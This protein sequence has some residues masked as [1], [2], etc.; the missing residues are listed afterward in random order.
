MEEVLNIDERGRIVIPARV[1]KA[2][3]IEGRR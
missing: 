1:R 3:G 2:L